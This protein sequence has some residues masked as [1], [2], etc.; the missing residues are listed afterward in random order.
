MFKTPLE[1]TI[2]T[3]PISLEIDT[4]VVA[5]VVAVFAPLITFLYGSQGTVGLTLLLVIIIMDWITGIAAAKK[6]GIYTSEYGIQGVFRSIVV[7]MIPSAAHLIDV[8]F[9]MP[10]SI[11]YSSI[12]ALAYHNGKSVT[13]NAVI[14]EWDRWIP[15]YLIDK[16]LS[17]IKN[18]KVRADYRRNELE[19]EEK[20]R[21]SAQKEMNNSE[22]SDNS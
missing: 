10:N 6:K 12:A 22:N 19:Y 2:G 16:V 15:T 18:K 3:N 8:M 11:F 9:E 21:K 17:E 13:A 1:K 7:L 14:A 5:G 20:R 4:G